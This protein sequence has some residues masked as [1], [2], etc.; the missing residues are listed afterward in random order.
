[1]SRK[2]FTDDPINNIDDDKLNRV[3]FSRQIVNVCNQV[4]SQ[5][6]T[7][8]MALIGPWGSGKSSVLELIR[9]ELK[10]DLEHWRVVNFNPWLFSDIESLLLNFFGELASALPPDKGVKRLRQKLGEYTQNISSVGKL[11]SLVGLDASTML[12]KTGELLTGNTSTESKRAAIENELG[13]LKY[14][15]L[16]IID[17]IDRLQPQ[18]LLQIFKLIRLV[19]RF[20]NIHYLVAYDERT[21]L[22]VLKRSD[23]VHGS[24]D[25]AQD[26]IQKIVQIRLDLPPIHDDEQAD[27]LDE[28]LKTFFET[29]KIRLSDTEWQQ[30]SWMYHSN[31]KPYLREPRSVIRFTAQ[32]HALYALVHEEVDTIDFLALTFMRTFEPGF[33]KVI[34]WHRDQL[35]GRSSSSYLPGFSSDELK[36][37]WLNTMEEN[38]VSKRNTELI[39]GLMQLLFPKALSGN[40]F[41]TTSRPKCVRSPDYFDRYFQ[42]GI[43]SSDIPDSEVAKVI[44]ELPGAHGEG[45]EKM[46]KV[47]KK[48]PSKIIRKIQSIHEEGRIENPIDVFSLLASI[49]TILPPRSGFTDAPD[50]LIIKLADSLITP[51][52]T[53]LAVNA[54]TAATQTTA[55]LLFA[56]ELTA[57]TMKNGPKGKEWRHWTEEARARVCEALIEKAKESGRSE[58]PDIATGAKLLQRLMWLESDENDVRSLAW[59]N[60]KEGNWNFISLLGSFVSESD[61]STGK[62]TIFGINRESLEAILG[63]EK[64]VEELGP[65]LDTEDEDIDLDDHPE[66]TKE[67]KEK[68]IIAALKKHKKAGAK[69]KETDQ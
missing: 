44:A 22:D 13:E 36:N 8:V 32:L 56:A 27:L 20:P 3:A 9:N 14:K 24:D 60:V 6:K 1:M 54:V 46:I 12:Q 51:L 67:N 17:D 26:Y 62:R 40:A 35:T 18:E 68:Y 69:T 2:F 28:R 25:R 29:H 52:Q 19:G 45:L 34:P 30:L 16:V 10:Q 43:P 31:L 21:V 11:G 41:D 42:F 39:Y 49:Y 37:A 59:S 33:Y 48:N 58:N 64:V 4:A 53:D 50:W 61:S 7:T 63:V 65:L 5:S 47:L 15:I 57:R 23:L 66:A 55:Q 38:A